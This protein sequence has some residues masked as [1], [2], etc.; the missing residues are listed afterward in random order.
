MAESKRQFNRNYD[1][2]LWYK[3]AS[4]TDHG[5]FGL[6]AAYCHLGNMSV[7]APTFGAAEP[8]WKGWEVGGEYAFAKNI[9]GYITYFDGENIADKGTD[10]KKIWSRS[11]YFF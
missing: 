2:E 3:G 6:Y 11:R 5:S 10:V 8:S 7:I 1:V 9:V 4:K